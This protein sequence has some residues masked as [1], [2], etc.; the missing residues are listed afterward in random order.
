VAFL[1]IIDYAQT[2]QSDLIVM[3]THGHTGLD[4]LISGSTAEQVV[5]TAPCPV[6][7]V[8]AAA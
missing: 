4:H 3:A 1:E 5:R 8:R 7:S 6:L 2:H